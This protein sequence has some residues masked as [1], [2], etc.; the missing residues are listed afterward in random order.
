MP[1]YSIAIDLSELVPPNAPFT[2]ETFP[3]LAY[4]VARLVD[5]AHAQWLAYANGAPLPDG[6]TISNR[7]GAYARSILLRGQGDFA[8]EV[9]SELPYARVI[10]EGVPQRDM[11]R[12]L[13][14]SFKVRVNKK[15]RRY[16][17]IPFRHN[18]GSNLGN[19]MPDMVQ[20]WWSQSRTPSHI[21]G[22]GHRASGIA[23]SDVRTKRQIMTPSRTY[24]WGSRLGAADLL[25]M[26]IDPNHGHGKRMVGMVNFRRPGTNKDSQHIT[27]RVMTEGGRGWISPARPGKHPAQ[28]TADRFRPLAREAFEQAVAADFARL[29]PG[30][31]V[32]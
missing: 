17:I 32:T 21:A 25:G 11:K 20:Q 10:E 28:I 23:G 9:Y 29:L 5:A 22:T 26:G 12:I 1:R 31:N 18:A 19:Q 14:T 6:G 3:H 13:D 4:S 2:A 16:L 15:G 27:F 24:S 8:A 30:S 7:T